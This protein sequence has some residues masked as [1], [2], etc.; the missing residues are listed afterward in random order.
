MHYLRDLMEW[1][2]IG[3]VGATDLKSSGPN[4]P[5][6]FESRPRQTL[7]IVRTCPESII[8][9]KGRFCEETQ[10]ALAKRPSGNAYLFVR[11]DFLIVA[12]RL[13]PEFRFLSTTLSI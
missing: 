11:E 3:R 13:E 12:R 1:R 8:A 9:G 4:G 5:C 6:G 10:T 2:P 7:I